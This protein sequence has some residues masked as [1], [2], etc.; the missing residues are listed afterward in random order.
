METIMGQ[1]KQKLHTEMGGMT[2]AKQ[3]TIRPKNSTVNNNSIQKYTTPQ[4]FGSQEMK[5]CY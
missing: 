3:K 1:H 4:T 2:T 5:P